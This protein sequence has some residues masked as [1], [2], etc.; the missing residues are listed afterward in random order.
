MRMRGVGQTYL[1]SEEGA[2]MVIW[3]VMLAAMIGLIALSFDIGRMAA[4]QSELQT[5]ADHVALAAAGEL[6]GRPDAIA[7]A[8]EAA[9]TLIRDQQTYADGGTVL[10]GDSFEITFLSG[11]PASDTGS[12]SGFETTDPSDAVIARVAI[13]PRVVET[14]FSA[15]FAFLS[16]T[17][18]RDAMVDAEAIAGLTMYACDVTPLMFCLPTPSWRA[19]DNVGRMIHLRSGGNGSAWGAGNFGFVDPDLASVDPDGPCAGLNGAKLFGCRLSAIGAVSQCFS[20]RGIDTEPGQKVGIEGALFNVRFDIYTSTM[21]GR[22]NDPA[23]APAPNVI[24][25]IV[26]KGRKSCIGRKSEVSRD[27]LGLPRD[28]CF[29]SGSCAHGGR[30]GDGDWSAGRVAYVLANYGVDISSDRS[31]DPH[32]DARTRYDYYKAEIAAAGGAASGRDIL[33]GR[34]E[35]GRPACSRQQADFVERRVVI[36]AGVDCAANS[37]RGRA[38]NVPVVEFVE[39]F[40]TEPVGDDGGSP[41]SVDIWGEVVGSAG[42]DGG[43]GPAGIFRDVVQLLR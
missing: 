11:L 39:I 9:T 19:E 10:D 25:G 43:G 38:T 40:L 22:K 2:V 18:P 16:G 12:V 21:S 15:A 34:A 29:A 36:A 28:D 35:S 8:K 31:L 27:T 3:G 24:K 6:D 1:K 37:I 42:G 14:S 30:F 26:P 33:S 7:R 32:A 23:Y 5:F 20:Q 17:N 13:A 41:A 4:S